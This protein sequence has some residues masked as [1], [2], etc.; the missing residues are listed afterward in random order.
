MRE[1]GQAG[2][3]AP[4]GTGLDL[5]NEDAPVAD[6]CSVE[7]VAY[8]ARAA[9]HKHSHATRTRRERIMCD[10]STGI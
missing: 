9:H 4:M 7:K 8:V 2:S 1:E 10:K 5:A 6:P 3:L